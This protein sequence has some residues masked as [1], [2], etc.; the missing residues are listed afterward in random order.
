MALE[1]TPQ[2][3]AQTHPVRLSPPSL[4]HL[5]IWAYLALGFVIISTFGVLCYAAYSAYHALTLDDI[6]PLPRYSNKLPTRMRRTRKKT[7][8]PSKSSA[9]QQQPMLSTASMDSERVSSDDIDRRMSFRPLE[10]AADHGHIPTVAFPSAAVSPPP[11]PRTVPTYDMHNIRFASPSN[12]TICT[13]PKLAPVVGSA[14][15]LSYESHNNLFANPFTPT[16]TSSREEEAAPRHTKS[17]SA[18]LRGKV[19][20]TSRGFGKE[21]SAGKGEEVPLKHLY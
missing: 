19:K 16:T 15:P 21:N 18:V 8:R 11:R 1:E 3:P 14:V 13:N 10:P 12:V 4:R 5:S 20:N 7:W 9:S 2:M 17:F 6:T